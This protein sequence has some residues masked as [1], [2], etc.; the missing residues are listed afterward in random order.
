MK[1]HVGEES[2][3]GQSR[4]QRYRR[5]PLIDYVQLNRRRSSTV[6]VSGERVRKAGSLHTDQIKAAVYAIIN[7]GR[8]S[9]SLTL[10]C[11][12]C[13]RPIAWRANPDVQTTD[14]RARR[15]Q[16]AHRVRREGTVSRS[17]PLSIGSLPPVVKQRA[18]IGRFRL[19]PQS[20]HRLASAQGSRLTL[21]DYV[22]PRATAVSSGCVRQPLT[23]RSG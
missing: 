17:L 21:S 15:G 9:S 2:E 1:H 12:R 20:R 6:A 18:V 3:P 7:N 22:A 14:W 5:G 4:V 10:G 13:M 8:T 23:R 19:E 16:T 11:S